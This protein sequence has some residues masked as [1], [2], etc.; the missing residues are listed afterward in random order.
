VTVSA[1]G[2]R[3]FVIHAPPDVRAQVESFPPLLPSEGARGSGIEGVLLTGADLDQV[4]GLLTLREGPPLAVHATAAVRRSLALG[5]SLPATLEAYAGAEWREP[6]AAPAP[7]LTRDGRPSGLLYA[8]FVL[9]G[10]PPRYLR[11]R[12][13]PSPGDCVGYLLVEEATGAGLVVAPALAALDAAILD[14][15]GGC[16]ALLLDGTF[17]RDDEL[18]RLGVG[19]LRAAEMGHVPV[20]GPAGSLAA[21][22]SLPVARKIY[23]HVNNTNPMLID[24]SPERQ[25][26]EAAGVEVGRDGMEIEL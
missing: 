9:P 21:V 24:D 3:W 11:G 13:G 14:R 19:T 22:R 2:R 23:V 25:A 8:A 6:P 26:V 17:W 7:L 10:Q 15:L 12:T 5:L 20:G 4:L 16:E 1:D 18:P